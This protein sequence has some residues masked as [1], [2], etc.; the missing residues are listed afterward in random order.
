MYRQYWNLNA[1][2]FLNVMDDRFV[3]MTEQHM[4]GLSRLIFLESYLAGL[5]NN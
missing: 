1:L 4:E 3:Y 5:F 2:P